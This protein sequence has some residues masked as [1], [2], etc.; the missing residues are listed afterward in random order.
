MSLKLHMMHSHL[1]FFKSNMGDYSEEHGEP[2]H[3][4]MMEFENRYQGQYNERMMGDYVWAL[5]Q[6]TQSLHRRKTR[7][8]LCFQS[9]V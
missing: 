4:D 3:Q 6:E 8:S 7:K 2:F 9:T 5:V 1:D